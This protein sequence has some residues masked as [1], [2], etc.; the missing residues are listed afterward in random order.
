MA[1][2][3]DR[4]VLLAHC[5]GLSTQTYIVPLLLFNAAKT[6]C[7]SYSPDG[8]IMR[9]AKIGGTVCRNQFNAVLTTHILFGVRNK[10]VRLD[11]FPALDP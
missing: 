8:D 10:L 4:S 7:A 2:L 9:F 1:M 11:P 6:A 5:L 3:R